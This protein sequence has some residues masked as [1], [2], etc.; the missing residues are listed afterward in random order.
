MLS[1]TLSQSLLLSQVTGDV[2]AAF[3]RPLGV[4][5]HVCQEETEGTAEQ[6][7]TAL[8]WPTLGFP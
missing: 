1:L 8:C 6:D 2:C 7:L 4:R 3:Q 5:V